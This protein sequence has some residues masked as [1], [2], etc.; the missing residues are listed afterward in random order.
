MTARLFAFLRTELALSPQRWRAIGRIVVA[1]A[2]A[3]TLI[4]TLR[5]PEGGWLILTIL[6]VSMPDTGASVLRAVQRLLGTLV[7]CSVAIAFVIAFPQQPWFLVPFIGASIGV[8]IYLSRTAAAPSIPILGTLTMVLAI[9]GAMDSGSPESITRAL[10]RL[11]EISAGNII[12]T[13]CQAFL[14]PE[15]PEKLL[16]EHLAKS[17]RYSRDRMNEVLLPRDQVVTNPERLAKSEERVMNSLAQWTNWLDNATHSGSGLRARHDDFMNLIGETN[18][19]AV[20]SQQIAR[21]AASMATDGNFATFAPEISQRVEAIR[22]RCRRYAAAIEAGVWLPELDALPPLAIDLSRAIVDVEGADLEAGVTERPS[23]DRATVLSSFLSIAQALDGMHDAVDFLRSESEHRSGARRSPLFP[24]ERQTFSWKAYRNV[25]KADVV[26]AGKGA[27]AATLAY[28]YLYTIDWPGGITA[29]VTAV[30]VCLD[31]YGAMIL[32]SVLRLIG[33]FVGGFVSLLVILYVI[34]QI[35]SLASFLIV[36]SL[37]F[38]L[39]AW[40]QTGS[41][42]ISYAGL[43]IGFAA[44]LCLINTHYPST[45]LMPFRDRM[46]GI[47]TGL[48]IV[49]MVYGIFGEVRARIW[50]IDN[51]VETLRLLARCSTLGFRD[52]T[53]AREQ[54]PLLGFRFEIF[55][56]MSFGYRLLTESMYEDWFSRDKAATRAERAALRQ[57]LDRI[58]SLQR[59]VLSLVWNRL[60]YQRRSDSSFGG[61]IEVE[62]VGRTLQEALEVFANRIDHVNRPDASALAAKVRFSE[63]LER[64]QLALEAHPVSSESSEDEREVHRLLH[65]QVGFYR[66]VE[67]L[68]GLLAQDAR[69]LHI[70]PDRFSLLARLRGSERRPESPQFRPA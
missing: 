20:A 26:S 28:I 22:E 5:I 60:D 68:L 8:G 50:A 25:R 11:V 62:A 41:A 42:R 54:S 35:T 9:P 31:N 53:P 24:Q 66:D 52:V 27:L 56:R 44:A 37:V 46:L 70:S 61:R 43:Q 7:G 48:V 1:C 33:A 32:K 57:L 21:I 64:A 36:T 23:D 12:G 15:R 18:Q 16:V 2:I 6:I 13:L 63:K 10:W 3:T 49:L 19:V 40:V 14:W 34:P 17:L 29:V 51:C 45:D 67:I 55:H 47:F 69:D 58:R 30:L 38:G 59:V 4:M 65:S 39:A